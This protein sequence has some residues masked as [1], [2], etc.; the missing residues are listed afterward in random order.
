MKNSN[1]KN[2]LSWLNDDGTKKT[3]AEIA[4]LGQNWS[5]Q[6]W[7]KYLDSSIGTLRDDNLIFISKITD[8]TYERSEV[9][10]FLNEK[11]HFEE[12]E[13]ALLIALS[14][15]SKNERFIIK[16]A[17]WKMND[18]KEIAQGLGKSSNTVAVLKSRAIKKLGSI[19][20]SQKLKNEIYQLKNT[21]RLKKVISDKKQWIKR[22]SLII[23]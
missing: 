19:L 20:S 5:A 1:S 4:Q 6:T 13:T 2:T 14:E 12:I 3:D 7:D 9:L 18:N 10:S 16:E 21:G 15:L 17:F 22:D 11:R 8:E 23:C